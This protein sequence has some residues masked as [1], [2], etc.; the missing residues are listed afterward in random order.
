MFVEVKFNV[1]PYK[2]PRGNPDRFSPAEDE[3]YG[4]GQIAEY[5]GECMERQHRLFFFSLYILKDQ[6]SIQIWDRDGMI[7]SKYK[8]YKK[9][10]M[11]LVRFLY[12]FVKMSDDQVGYDPTVSAVAANSEDVIRMKAKIEGN[13]FADYPNHVQKYVKE[14]MKAVLRPNDLS[15]GEAQTP[16][17]KV[18]V[19]ENH[20]P[21]LR[22]FLIGRRFSSSGAEPFGRGT[23]GYVAYDLQED[24]FVFL[25]D[26]W[27]DSS[28]NPEAST[29]RLL[30]KKEVQ[31]I[32]TLC[33]GGDMPGQSTITHPFLD[34]F[35]QPM[36]H[37][38]LVLKEIGMPLKEYQT[39]QQLCSFV[40]SALLAHQ[41]AYEDAQILHRDISENN[42]VI[43]AERDA[44][45]DEVTTGVLID[46]DLS[47]SLEQL[48]SNKFSDGNRS[49][50]WYYLS[51]P[52][53]AFPGKP[54]E[55]P[56]DLESFVH[57]I[58]HFALR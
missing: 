47:K 10:P 38:R 51:A 25:K 48:K 29:Y 57:L 41:Y 14:A 3:V 6:F 36:Y 50:T 33:C 44:E 21:S 37:H 32:A 5:A 52:R 24:E 26:A 30:E 45:G 16:I 4:R 28:S 8:D 19:P 23:K 58:N 35:K 2:F 34:N 20:N 54:W 55:L 39:S 27:R 56:D 40:Y 42:I 46:W 49:G 43:L 18:G 31:N 1:D 7:M 9:D 11:A 53:L 12:Y 15:K 13:T 17:Y 22:H